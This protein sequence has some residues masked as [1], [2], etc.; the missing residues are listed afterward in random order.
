MKTA[1]L[2]ASLGREVIKRLGQLV[3]LPPA[4]LL[5]GQAVASIINLTPDTAIG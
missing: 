3:Q 2:D 5:A 1:V 4:G